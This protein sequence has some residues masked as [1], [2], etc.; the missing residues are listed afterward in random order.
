LFQQIFVVVQFFFISV[1]PL[2]GF[3][4]DDRPE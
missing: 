2:G 3:I 4:G 1:M